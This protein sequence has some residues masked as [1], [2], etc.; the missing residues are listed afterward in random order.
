MIFY[1][2]NIK[3]KESVYFLLSSLIGLHD[4]ILTTY[5]SDFLDN[6]IQDKIRAFAVGFSIA[7]FLGFIFVKALMYIRYKE[8]KQIQHLFMM[9]LLFLLLIFLVG[10]LIHD[11]IINHRPIPFL[12][13]SLIY[14]LIGF[15]FNIAIIF[16]FKIFYKD[17]SADTNI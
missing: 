16:V 5:A 15:I 17:N 13:G 8:I 7:F 12:G 2:Y 10:S 14:L 4:I 6:S 1:S 9:L 11:D 3:K